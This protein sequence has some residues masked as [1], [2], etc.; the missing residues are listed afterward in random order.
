MANRQVLVVSNGYSLDFTQVSRMLSWLKGAQEA[1]GELH[2]RSQL[3]D[4]IGL[5]IRRTE[6]LQKLAVAMGLIESSSLKLTSLGN[7][8]ATHDLY[9][10]DHGTLWLLHYLVGSRPHLYVWNRMVNEVVQQNQVFSFDKAKDAF[11]DA[12]SLYSGSTVMRRVQKEITTFLNAYTQQR[13]SRLAYVREGQ[14]HTYICGTQSPIPPRMFLGAVMSYRQRFLPAAVTL[15]VPNLAHAPNGPGR[16]FNQTE[17][18][19]RDL[20]QEAK[21]LDHIYIETR[22]DLD[23]I[24]LRDDRGFLDIVRQHY[25]GR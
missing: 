11:S 15:D 3:A 1:G 21:K 24:R 13:F 6:A 12:M 9:F 2:N 4:A 20:L 7:L 5:S 16:V 22:A 10:A 18:Q 25:E 14:R 19:V 23:Q 8:V 17:R